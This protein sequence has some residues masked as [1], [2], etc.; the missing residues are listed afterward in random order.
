MLMVLS[1]G[2][3]TPNLFKFIVQTIVEALEQKRKHSMRGFYRQ[4]IRITRIILQKKLF[5]INF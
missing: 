5:N 1:K 3:L 2:P 4:S